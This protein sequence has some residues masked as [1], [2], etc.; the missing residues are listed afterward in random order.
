M[1]YK[2]GDRVRI[3]SIDWYNK[4]KDKFSRVWTSDGQIPFEK[5]MSHFCGKVMTISF[6]GIN[7]YA[8]IGDFVAHWT[9][10]MIEGLA[11]EE[12]GLID[13]FS[14]RWINEFNLPEGYI[15]KDENGNV[16]NAT[17]IVMEKKKKE[18]PKTYEE[19]AKVLLDRASVRNDFGYKGELLVA[20]QKLLVCRDAYW[21]I[22][23][24]EMG[25]GKPWEP[26][27]EEN[28][29]KSVITT[30]KNAVA[31]FNTKEQ[32]TFAFPTEEMRD[33]FY[34]NFKVLIEE[35]KELL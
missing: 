33:A 8:M 2:V 7:Y 6:V 12:V 27:W 13:K 35:C 29:E 26:N 15:F 18:Y 31:K 34:E 5:Y 25:L 1:N 32:Y 28:Y 10:E 9:D 14:S 4:N 30:F 24:A 3:K 16:I 20:L 21:K 19:C 17:K 23:G 22:A 11:E